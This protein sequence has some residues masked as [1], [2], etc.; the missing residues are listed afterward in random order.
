M[1]SIA[2][3]LLRI[4][5]TALPSFQW[6]FDKTNFASQNAKFTSFI[7]NKFEVLP[8]VSCAF[9]WKFSAY[10][11]SDVKHQGNQR[12]FSNFLFVW[13]TIPW[14]VGWLFW[15]F[16]WRERRI[17]P[18]K[19]VEFNSREYSTSE[20]EPPPMRTKTT[21]KTYKNGNL[22][23]S[24]VEKNHKKEMHTIEWQCNAYKL[25]SSWTNISLVLVF[26]SLRTGRDS[27]KNSLLTFLFVQTRTYIHVMWMKEWNWHLFL[28]EKSIKLNV[29]IH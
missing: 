8:H 17:D 28:S 11:V 20:P 24:P 2:F 19:N 4:R 16:K 18:N 3:F 7:R 23:A 5:Q 29:P 15:D 22:H 27:S 25:V 13:M 10:F 12:N 21:D 26:L 9:C 1:T 6:K 14:Q